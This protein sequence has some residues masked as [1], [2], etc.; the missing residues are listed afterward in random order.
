V[1]SRRGGDRDRAGEAVLAVG[2]V[3]TRAGDVSSLPARTGRDHL[4]S[5]VGMRLKKMWQS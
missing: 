4:E 5:R 1:A 2:D 3:A